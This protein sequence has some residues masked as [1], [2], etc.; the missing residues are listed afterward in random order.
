MKNPA[1]LLVSLLALAALPAFAADQSTKYDGSWKTYLSLGLTS[2][3][4]LLASGNYANN[5]K[6]FSVRAGGGM[7]VSVGK[8]YSFNP[9][10]S[11]Q[12][13]VGY[14]RDETNG[15]NGDFRFSRWPVEATVYRTLNS[16]W[17][18]GLG[19]R[20]SLGATFN[21]RGTVAAV[22]DWD[23][24]ASPGG[25]AEVQYLFQPLSARSEGAVGGVSLR[26]VDE[27]FQV[28]EFKNLERK[29][30]HIGVSLFT[31]F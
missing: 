10:W 22:G 12:G 29:G 5:G 6:A 15:E 1:C 9:D 13:S 18:V 7:Q 19:L 3:G 24:K 2:G 26:L 25:L 17:R 31:Y 30:Q 8:M 4:D 20:Q 14:H 27:R 28:K 11:L 21:S 16:S 23:M